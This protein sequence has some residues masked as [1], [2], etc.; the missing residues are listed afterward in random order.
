[1]IV[2]YGN[3]FHGTVKLLYFSFIC[4]NQLMDLEFDLTWLV[5]TAKYIFRF[6]CF[7]KNSM[8]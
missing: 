6:N 3:T 2:K 1:M 4:P 8:V 5:Q 7:S